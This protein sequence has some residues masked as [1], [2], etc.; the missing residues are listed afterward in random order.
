[1]NATRNPKPPSGLSDL[2]IHPQR[3]NSGTSARGAANDLGAILTPSKMPAP[4]VAPWVKEVYL[5]PGLW[6]GRAQFSGL[7]LIAERATQAEIL[8]F[9]RAPQCLRDDMIDVKGC[10]RHLLKSLAIL[11]SVFRSGLNE[12]A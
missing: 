9:T 3:N 2:I 4:T 12:L 1:M 7:E 10:E 11:A 6:V 8:K 5:T